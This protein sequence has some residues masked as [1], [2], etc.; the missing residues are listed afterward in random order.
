MSLPQKIAAAL[1]L[2]VEAAD[3]RLLLDVLSILVLVTLSG[4][5]ASG[6]PLALKHLVD[7]VAGMKTPEATTAGGGVL[8]A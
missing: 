7:A 8:L 3:R 6:S 4:A 1:G 2:I 5:L